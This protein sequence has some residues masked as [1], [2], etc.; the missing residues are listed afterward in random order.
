MFRDVYSDNLFM[1]V[2]QLML[3]YSHIVLKSETC[4]IYVFHLFLP[5]RLERTGTGK[6]TL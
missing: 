2:H 3:K 4:L 5:Y 6:L 1:Y